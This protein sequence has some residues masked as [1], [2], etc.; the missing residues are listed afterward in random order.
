MPEAYG[1]LS[2]TVPPRLEEAFIDWLLVVGS[3]CGF[4]SFP[5][6]G[7]SGRPAG[8]TLAEQ[9]SG[10]KQNV[11]FEVCLPAAV[12]DALIEALHRDFPSAGIVYWTTPINGFGR[13]PPATGNT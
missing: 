2:L 9:V 12:I 5:V 10:R 7:H 1:L 4:T 11:R 6:D 13:V 3:G 8:M